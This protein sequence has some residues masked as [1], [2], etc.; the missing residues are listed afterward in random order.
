MDV[1]CF[2]CPFRGNYKGQSYNS[3]EPPHRVFANAG[4]CRRFEDFITS[5][6][7][8]RLR[9]GSVSVLGEVWIDPP[10]H[11]ILPLLIEPSKPRM[12]CNARF[13]NLWIRN[14]P[15]VLDTLRD[16]PRML[17]WEVYMTKCDGKSCFDHI[18]LKKV[19]ARSSVSNGA[20]STIHSIPFRSVKR[21][22]H[23]YIPTHRTGG[24]NA[25]S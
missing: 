18:K 9:N 3:T 6:I 14:S 20:S 23:I 11:L 10:P 8:E 15:F 13:L 5:T 21:Q 2:F 25:F 22:A 7:T 19:A 1:R 4:S 16:V 12:C 24:D 17:Q